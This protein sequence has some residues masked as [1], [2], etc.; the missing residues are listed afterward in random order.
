VIGSYISLMIAKVTCGGLRLDARDESQGM[1][2]AIHGEE[3]YNLE[4]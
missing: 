3:G 2:L 1:D 4:T